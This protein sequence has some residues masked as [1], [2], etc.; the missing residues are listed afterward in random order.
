MR[1]DCG[2]HSW[3]Y[4][5]PVLI[6]GAYDE[7]GAP[8]A[9]NAAWGGLYDSDLV[10]LC[11][12]EGHKTTKNIK[13]KKAFTVSFAD[14][15]HVVEADYLGIASGNQ[16]SDKLA[17]AG[18]HATKS[19]FVDAPIIDEFLMALECELV[20]VTEEGNIIGRIVNIS[21]DDSVLTPD[22]TVD[23]AKLR[24]ISFDPCAN[25]YVELGSVV[26]KAFQDGKKLS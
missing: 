2:V 6:V 13:A 5:L 10:E 4:P 17:K 8:N 1:K 20:K 19:K 18:L 15:A 7:S 3:F 11:L 24:P 9:M 22:G 12:S 21:V 23:V 26:G 14:A 16:V 25:T